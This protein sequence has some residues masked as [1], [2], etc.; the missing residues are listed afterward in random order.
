VKGSLRAKLSYAN[1]T[2]TL[3]L[4]IALSGATAYAA[5]QLAPKSVGERQLRPGAV[6]A[7]KIRK[8]A[9]SAPKIAALAV[10][11]GKLA[12]G[13][14]SASK[15]APGAVASGSLATGSVTNEKLANDSVTGEKVQE[16]TLSQVPSAA[17][18]D[19]AT[20]AESANP[21]AFA[22]VDLEG[23]VNPSL[24]KDVGVVRKAAGVYCVSALDFNPRGAQVT[25]RSP[26]EAGIDAYATIGGTGSCP[27]PGVEVD[28]YKV[29]LTSEAFYVSLYR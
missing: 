5:N 3:A 20:S 10:K 7:E 28:T 2:A 4:F 6:T 11:E 22:A 12:G 14:V 26:G 9:V 24:S 25:P 1:V 29:V 27:A 13:A 18:A 8:N 23:N 21:L 15:L 19:F 17:R 16:G